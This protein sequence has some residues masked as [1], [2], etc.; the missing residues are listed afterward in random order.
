MLFNI[1]VILL[2]IFISLKIEKKFK[3][4]SPLTLIILSILSG[5]FIKDFLSFTNT[6]VF[7]EEMLVFIVILVLGDAFKLKLKDL[8]ENYIS[9]I[10]LAGISVALAIL[11]GILSKEIIFQN[12]N[13][14]IGSLIVLFAMVTATDP[15]SVV[16]VFNQYK[17]PHK[18]K[19][20][21]EGESLFN[22][23]MA[24]TLFSAFGL[25][26]MNN[27]QITLNY[28]LI[29]SGEIFTGS[30][31]IGIIIGIIGLMLLK[32]TKDLLSE[33]VLILLV[34]YSAY[35]LAEHVHIIGNNHLSGLLSEIIAILTMTTIIDKSYRNE[36]LRYNKEKELITKKIKENNIKINTN[37][38]KRIDKLINKF[39]L[40]ITDIKRQ[41][42]IYKFINVISLLANGVLFV[43]LAHIINFSS[44]N[45]YLYEIISVF[46]LTTIIRISLIG[47]FK[48]LSYKVKSIPNINKYWFSILT[49]AGIK[50]GLSIVMLHIL[51]TT[52]P[53][54]EFKEMF[55]SIVIGVILLS[56]F[57]YV[58]LMMLIININQ[59]AKNN[60]EI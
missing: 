54:F 18:L 10:Y 46:I 38:E 11:L 39:V 30:M 4:A 14:S 45:K 9:I 41:D 29:V 16:S 49:L 12:L 37:K 53:E 26:M 24:L 52:F 55:E 20:L 25:Y 6:E 57:I 51:N 48:L 19:I 13:I 59:K 3:I 35:L 34:A 31:I 27:N 22:D 21:A 47:L 58:P 36:K 33:F 40:D 17:L 50:G 56:T 23:A 60:T 8:K 44:L 5:I 1:V 15:V 28:S 2:M 42:D 43:S 32:T 7:S